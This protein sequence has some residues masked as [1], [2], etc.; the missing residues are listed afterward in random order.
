MRDE[1][2]VGWHH[3]FS[4][5][6][7]E[8]TLGDGEGQGSLL[9]CSPWGRKEPETLNCNSKGQREAKSCLFVKRWRDKGV[10]D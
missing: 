2:L 1:E 10:K 8:Q 3:C 9:R 6:G 7:F 5:H 4:G